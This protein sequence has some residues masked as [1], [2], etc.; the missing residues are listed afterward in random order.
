[1]TITITITQLLPLFCQFLAEFVLTDVMSKIKQPAGG[2]CRERQR[3]APE[4][5]RHNKPVP[6]RHSITVAAA[7]R[8]LRGVS[9]RKQAMI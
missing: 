6:R 7:H 3:A 4:A 9:F 5:N 2:R 8:W 1:M